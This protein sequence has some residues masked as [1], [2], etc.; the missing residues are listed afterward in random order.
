MY[1]YSS[2]QTLPVPR[3]EVFSF[4]SDPANLELLTPDYL[5]FELDMDGP[6]E[7]DEGALLSY[8]LSLRGIPFS[9]T[10]RVEVWEPPE[11]FVD[12]QL[13]GPYRSWRH[14][15]VF[16]EVDGGTRVE[17]HVEYE[18]PGWFL[19]PLINWM[20]VSGDVEYIFSYRQQKL[21][22]RFGQEA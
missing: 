2:E 9:W 1:T 5:S 10:S 16:H 8:Q 7:M 18:V 11:R 15:H 19:A 13:K 6:V 22:E 14:E 20:F 12:V 3:P 4:F 17:D 21:E